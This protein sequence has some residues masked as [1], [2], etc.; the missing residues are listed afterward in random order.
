MVACPCRSD[1]ELGIQLGLAP[2]LSIM[3]KRQKLHVDESGV[4]NFEALDHKT[5]PL[6][7]CVYE[8]TQT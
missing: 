8:Y 7:V 5:L 2:A 3:F 1:D 6:H 4:T